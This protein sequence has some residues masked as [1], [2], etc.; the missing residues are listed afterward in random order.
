V[1]RGKGTYNLET[2]RTNRKRGEPHDWQRDATSPRL[3]AEK[4]DE[5]VR[6][7]EVGTGLLARYA[8]G[9]RRDGD[10]GPGVDAKEHVDEGAMRSD[11]T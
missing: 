6:N 11:D 3:R 5:V 9:R 10:I 2:G 4:T 7:H 1:R 8:R